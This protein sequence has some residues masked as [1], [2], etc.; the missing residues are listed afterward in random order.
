MVEMAVSSHPYVQVHGGS[1]YGFVLATEAGARRERVSTHEQGDALQQ[2]R[3]PLRYCPG[4]CGGR[5]WIVLVG[6]NISS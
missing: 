3:W 1:I 5:L 4:T 6:A 2:V